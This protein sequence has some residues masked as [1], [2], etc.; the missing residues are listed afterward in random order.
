MAGR[1]VE[2]VPPLSQETGHREQTHEAKDQFTSFLIMT[3]ATKREIT[4]N[5]F[6]SSFWGKLH[7][8]ASR[9]KV[10]TEARKHKN[11]TVLLLTYVVRMCVYVV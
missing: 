4:L 3:F 6:E 10:Y 5:S 1:P 7:R 8:Y 11:Q 2:K 9:L